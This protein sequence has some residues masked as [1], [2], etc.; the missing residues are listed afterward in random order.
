MIEA[1]LIRATKSPNHLLY[2]DKGYILRGSLKRSASHSRA[3][4]LIARQMV[5]M[6]GMPHPPATHP[7]AS[8]ASKAGMPI[9]R[10]A[11]EMWATRLGFS[12]G[13]ISITRL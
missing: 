9:T 10:L 5:N 7:A 6:L 11:I 8:G 2:N 12:A 4:R 3:A 13:H 1:V